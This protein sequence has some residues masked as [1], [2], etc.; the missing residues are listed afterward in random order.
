MAKAVSGA[1][2]EGE[3]LVVPHGLERRRDRRGVAGGLDGE[4]GGATEEG[5]LVGRIPGPRSLRR[6]EIHPRR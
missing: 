3:M 1:S 2:K 4:E 5:L 6:R